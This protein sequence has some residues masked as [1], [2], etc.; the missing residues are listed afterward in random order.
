MLFTAGLLAPVAAARAEEPNAAVQGVQDEDLRDQIRAAIGTAEHAATSRFE[1]RRRGRDAAESAIAVLR[2]EGYYAGEAQSDLADREDDDS[3]APPRAVVKVTP[4]PRFRIARPSIDWVN[5]PPSPEVQGAG[6]LAMAL[7]RGAPGRAE[8][9]IAAEGRILSAI[10]QRGH[11]DA[12]AMPREVIVDHADKTVRPTFRI[13]A[14]PLVRLDS[15]VLDYQGRTRPEWIARLTPWKPGT[16]YAPDELAELE[17]RLRETGAYE[18]VQVSLQPA[19]QLTEDGLRPVLLTLRDRPRR[20]LEVGAGY[21]TSEGAGLDVTT[22]RYNGWRRADTRVIALRLAEIQQRLDYRVSLPHWRKPRQ[23]LTVTASAY[24]EQTDAY[25]QTGASLTA[26]VTRRSGVNAYVTYGAAISGGRVAEILTIGNVVLRGVDRNLFDI[27]LLGAVA[28]DHSDDPLDP[29]RGWR[30]EARAEPIATFGDAQLAYL[31]LQGQGS[32]YLPLMDED[33]LVLATRVKLGVIA[34]ADPGD[35]PAARR[36]YSGGGGSVRGYGYQAVGPRISSTPLGGTSLAEGSV[37]LRYNI[38]ER[39][40]VVGF[41][42]IGA[43]GADSF[44]AGRDFSAGAGIGVRYNLGFGPIRAD[45]AIPL[46]PRDNDPAFQIYI[47]IGQA[48]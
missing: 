42:D 28:L 3:E 35:V 46:D 15:V 33:R 21:S 19:D 45:I 1:A 40:G 31:K 20:S 34:G 9:V 41:V 7:R 6:S 2:S 29:K 25:D 18:S 12:K 48:F 30:V 37:E 14:G 5:D 13:D 47:S 26:D 16:I 44:P 27:S 24:N 32:Y 23:T 10:Q 36:F 22:T 4:G 38:T 43:V 8:D 39:W 11:A 17:R